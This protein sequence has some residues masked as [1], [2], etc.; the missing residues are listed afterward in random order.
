MKRILGV[1]AVVC[2]ALCAHAQTLTTVTASNIQNGGVPLASGRI[3]FQATDGNNNPIAIR[4]L[5]G[6]QQGLYPFCATVTNG[7]I[8]PTFQVPN[9]QYTVPYNVP[10]T[11][12]VQDASGNPVLTYLS[13]QFVGTGFNFDTYTPSNPAPIGYSANYFS[14]GTGFLTNYLDINGIAA[15]SN[16]GSG[17]ARVFFNSS[18]NL[19]S[20]LTSSGGNCNPASGGGVTLETNGTNNASQTVLNIQ[21]G[22]GTTASNPSGGN[23]Q[24]NV[25]YGTSANTAAQGNDSRITG[26]SGS[27]ACAAHQ[28]A[29]TLNG[30]AAPTCTQPGYSDISGTPT[31][32]YQTVQNASGTAMTQR[33]TVEFTGAGISSVTDD[34]ANNRTVVAVSGGGGS[35]AG[36]TND[37]QLNLSN[38]FGVDSGNFIFTPSN[39]HLGILSGASP[40]AFVKFGSNGVSGFVGIGLTSAGLA[41]GYNVNDTNFPSKQYPMGYIDG[42][43]YSETNAGANNAIS[44]SFF[45]AATVSGT[46]IAKFEGFVDQTQVSGSSTIPSWESFASAPT[47]GSGSH[48]NRINAFEADGFLGS[49]TVGTVVGFYCNNGSAGFCVVEDNAGPNYLAGD[50]AVHFQGTPL[51]ALDINATS[52]AN[53]F[54]VSSSGLLVNYGGETT[55]GRGT[56][57]IRGTASQKS[58]AGTADANVLTVTPAS[59][60]GSYRACFSASVSSAT[61]GVIGWTLSWTDSNG[62]AQSNIAQQLFQMGTTA[63][64][65]T[66][67]TSAAGNYYG[68]SVIDVNSAGANII[69][70]WVGGGTTAAKVSAMVE[71]LQ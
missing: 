68:C 29:S 49:G 39:H 30:N 12:R 4:W 18:S 32:Y 22:T 40:D 41:T 36:S 8:V 38:A 24:V 7:A 53:S 2:F 64:N 52:G 27:G 66:F 6:G 58:E 50:L 59:A 23:V 70:K 35:P 20:C 1:V 16:P 37:V 21:N 60:A 48:I 19:L 34:P 42:N 28:W 56:P 31:L 57:V 62:N 33:P 61:S 45:S 25:T 51:N 17:F 44:G 63:P 11:V 69:V 15:P 71:R 3:C 9:P 55:A 14:F 47:V 65:T 46:G 43:S 26:A 13:V 5:G 10:Y 67:T 54:S